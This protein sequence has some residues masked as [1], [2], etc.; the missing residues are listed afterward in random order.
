MFAEPRTAPRARSVR[1]INYAGGRCQR[2][3]VY[4]R[5]CYNLR[6]WFADVS[7]ALLLHDKARLLDDNE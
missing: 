6:P 1:A 2:S 5:C 4:T 3:E 7:K